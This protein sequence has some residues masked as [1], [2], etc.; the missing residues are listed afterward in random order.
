VYVVE[1]AADSTTAY[2]TR[3]LQL[4]QNETPLVDHAWELADIIEGLLSCLLRVH[5]GARAHRR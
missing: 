1:L 5:S 3:Q 4:T 2:V